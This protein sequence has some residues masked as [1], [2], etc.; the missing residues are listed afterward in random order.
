LPKPPVGLTLYAFEAQHH[1][2]RYADVD[3]VGAGGCL[4]SN[5]SPDQSQIATYFSLRCKY[6][7][8]GNKSAGPPAAVERSTEKGAAGAQ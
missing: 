4:G 8:D 7:M 3:H 5:E 1:P 6:V 2:Q